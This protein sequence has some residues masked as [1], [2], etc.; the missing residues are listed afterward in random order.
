MERRAVRAAVDAAAA[1][2]AAGDT[3]AL[4]RLAEGGRSAAPLDR[5]RARSMSASNLGMVWRLS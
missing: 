2:A 1:A 4:E 5:G 3:E